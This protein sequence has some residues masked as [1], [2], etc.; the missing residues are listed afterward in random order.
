FK[1][2]T[3]APS[4]PWLGLGILLGAF[5]AG[6]CWATKRRRF[7]PSKLE[8]RLAFLLPLFSQI[9]SPVSHF[10]SDSSLK[11]LA[12]SLTFNLFVYREKHPGVTKELV[13]LAHKVFVEM[14]K[15]SSKAHGNGEGNDEEEENEP[16]D[17]EEGFL[18]EDEAS[19][20]EQG[21]CVKGDSPMEHGQAIGFDSGFQV[22][23]ASPSSSKEAFDLAS[24]TQDMAGMPISVSAHQVLGGRSEPSLAIGNAGNDEDDAH[25]QSSGNGGKHG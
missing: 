7:K 23:S 12:L 2:G 11:S 5:P 15:P 9:P 8:F 3:S 16:D 22:R 14:P 17:K 19:N 20:S 1:E 10:L 13:A 4:C 18:T 6:P 24:Q 25:I 21:R